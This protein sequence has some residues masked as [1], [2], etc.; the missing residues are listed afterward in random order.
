MTARIA[1]LTG[2]RVGF[3]I[4][5]FVES[6]RA[7]SQADAVYKSVIVFALLA[8]FLV[9]VA[10]LAVEGVARHALIKVIGLSFV[11]YP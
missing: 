8:D 11:A 9:A 10:L 2:V 5:F 1:D 3:S 6:I 4:V 7:F